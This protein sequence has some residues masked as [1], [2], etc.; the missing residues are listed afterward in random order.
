M[1]KVSRNETV[2]ER[3]EG[4]WVWDTGGNRFLDATAGLWYCF[5][6]H[7]RRELA[8]VAARQMRT[9]AAYSTFQDFA[10]LPASTLAE[11]VVAISP[12]PDS[13]VFFTS[14]GSE[15]IE[16]AAKLV[17]RYWVAVGQPERQLLVTRGGAYHGVAGYGT[18]LTGIPANAANFGELVPGVICI[19]P[20]D[21]HALEEVI[22]KYP[23]K[24]AGFFGE[25]VRGAGG[26]YPPPADYWTQIQ[27]I[28][29][30]N[31]VLL[32]ADEVVTGFG[33]LGCWFASSRFG[34][35]PD[36]ITGAKGITS[37]YQP[38]GVVICGPRVQEPFWR[39]DGGIFRHGY[40]YSGH[41]TACAVGIAN[42]E[43]IENERLLARTMELEPILEAEMGRLAQHPMVKEVRSIGLMA[44]FE[45]TE[46]ALANSST[47]VDDVLMEARHNG[48]IT[49]NLLGRAL[50][51][52]PPLVI[53]KDELRFMVDGFV[54]AL[55]RAGNRVAVAET[56]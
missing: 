41:A 34:I 45:L 4:V 15:S 49:R 54:L 18:S 27:R 48:I 16:T 36:I 56:A 13:V 19:P 5:V 40:T 37:G 44:A 52:S 14:G 43:I 46:E 42:L 1:V 28:C 39:G 2:I 29:R 12:M 47:A 17:R 9:L 3:G 35:E 22:D 33:R 21:P 26:V 51:I 53:T 7:G 6:G 24:V 55:N 32:V 38:L 20:D 10:N 50:Q 25:P 11:A 31:D 23:Q 8:D 30:K